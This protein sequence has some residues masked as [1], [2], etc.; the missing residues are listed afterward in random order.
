[1]LYLSL[2]FLLVCRTL[3]PKSNPRF[4]P[5]SNV[6]LFTLESV[7]LANNLSCPHN[8][9]SSKIFWLVLVTLGYRTHNQMDYQTSTK[10]NRLPRCHLDSFNYTKIGFQSDAE[11]LNQNTQSHVPML[12]IKKTPCC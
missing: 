1:M 11:L 9:V 3:A 10:T 7:P 5:V 4:W 2:P 6:I 12:P 8:K